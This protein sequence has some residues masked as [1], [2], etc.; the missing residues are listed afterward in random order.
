MEIIQFFKDLEP[1]VDQVFNFLE[2]RLGK[3]IL[4]IS[5]LLLAVLINRFMRW[6]LLSNSNAK[7][8]HGN[9]RATW[10]RRK[11]LVWASGVF[12]VLALWSGQITGFLISLAAIGGALLIVSKE[13][14]L[15]LWGALIISLNKNLKIGSTIEVG[16]FTG[17]LVN[18]GF[19]T[20]DLAEIGPSKKQTGRL[21]SLPNSLVFVEPMKNLSV[22]GAYGIHLIDFNMDK[23]VKIQF[24]ES[25][26]L[27]L[28]VEAGKHWIDEAERHFEAVERDNFV[29]LPKARP[30]V[31]WTSVDDKCL[32]MTLRLACPLNKRGQL[33]KSIVK[34]FWIE[35]NDMAQELLL[36]NQQNQAS[37][38]SDASITSRI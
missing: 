3:L 11:N 20:F 34:R 12:L 29:D 18:T 21:L 1:V 6:R 28:A 27:K 30:E 19:V 31:F 2:G 24:A 23:Q 38:S 33:E 17:Q 4:S 7:E 25:L 32:R 5:I 14:I 10:V 35:Y 26:V 37:Q 15:C 13:F 36:K 8:P 9:V 22:Y 16:K